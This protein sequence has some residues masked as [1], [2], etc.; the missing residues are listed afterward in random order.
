V[1]VAIRDETKLSE[2]AKE[3]VVVGGSSCD[4]SR[5]R[6]P[7]SSLLRVPLSRVEKL[8]AEV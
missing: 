6:V 7:N 1:E 5:Q 8:G 3:N 4:I 2:C